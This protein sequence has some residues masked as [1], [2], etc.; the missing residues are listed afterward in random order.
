MAAFHGK[1]TIAEQALAAAT[2]E[3]L[4]QL[5][6]AANHRVKIISWSVSFDG[7]SVTAEPVQVVLQRQTTAG[8]ASANTPVKLDDSIADTLLTAFQDTFTVEPT[9]TD[10]LEAMEV[11]PQQGYE[12]I[13]PFG[14]EPIVGGGDRIGIRCT[15]PAVVNARCSIHFEE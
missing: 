12:K 6:A 1:A 3:T 15:A 9:S 8:T 5:V 14:A 7:V 10:V 2:I 11:H 4:L 13:Y